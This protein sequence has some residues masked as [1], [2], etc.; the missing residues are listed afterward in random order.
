M[1]MENLKKTSLAV[2]I[3]IGTTTICASV[4][5]MESKTELEAISEAHNSYVSSGVFCEEDVSLI[6]NKAQKIL[7][8]IL[9]KHSGVIS[10]GI[11]GQMHGIAYVNENGEAVSNLITWQDGRADEI[12]ENGKTACEEIFA[13]TNEKISSGYGVATHYY[14]LKKGLVPKGSVRFVSI[15]E[16]FAMK[17]CGIKDVPTH[18]SVGASFGL[19]DLEKGEFMQG[20]LSRLGIDTSFLPRVTSKSAIIGKCQGIDVSVPIGDNQASFLGSV[21][22]DDTCALVNFGT[23]SQISSVGDYCKVDKALE[24]RPFVEGKYLVCGSALCGGYAYS[25]LESFFRG[26]AERLG[27]NTSQYK[28]INALAKEA[29]ESGKEGLSVDTA[30]LGKRS[31]PFVRG[32]IQMIDSK[33]FTPEELTLGVLKGMV[34]ELYSLYALFPDKK[35]NIIASGGAVR[36][37]EILKKLICDI[38]GTNLRVSDLSEEAAL[39]AAI[40]SLISVGK[41][42]Y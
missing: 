24:L 3:D 14:N 4:Y 18:A 16:L 25:M 32:S 37:N 9:D 34:N 20:K 31:D 17:I 13:L 19:F 28:I 15:M 29:Y 30:F 2:G 12:L 22:L 23:G 41:I 10:I 7:Y 33:N 40:F 6:I 39:G 8:G 26:Y 36:K 27:V 21:G 1:Q 11:T 5:D 42:K 38:F 35:E